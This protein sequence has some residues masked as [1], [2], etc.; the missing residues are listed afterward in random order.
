MIPCPVVE[1]DKKW[2]STFLFTSPY[3]PDVGLIMLHKLNSVSDIILKDG[4][5]SNLEGWNQLRG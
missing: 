1:S 5:Y 4:L 3:S 2:I